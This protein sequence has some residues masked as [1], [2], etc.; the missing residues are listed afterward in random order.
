MYC[1][2]VADARLRLALFLTTDINLLT[3]TKKRVFT[4]NRLC[5]ILLPQLYC[6]YFIYCSFHF[7]STDN[8]F[9]SSR[10]AGGAACPFTYSHYMISILH[11]HMVLHNYSSSKHFL[12]MASLLLVNSLTHRIFYEVG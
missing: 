1:N 4:Y 3:D 12:N 11:P 9:S 7:S 5:Y 8:I 2:Y 6:C 10:G